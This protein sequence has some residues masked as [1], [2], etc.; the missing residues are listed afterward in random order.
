MLKS[1]HPSPK[2]EYL[3]PYWSKR[4]YPGK[5]AVD[6]LTQ[7]IIQNKKGYVYNSERIANKIANRLQELGWVFELIIPVPNYHTESSNAKAPALVK[8]LSGILSIPYQNDVLVRSDKSDPYR[9]YH[10]PG[11]R[12]EAA[13][14]DYRIND[15]ILKNSDH[16]SVRMI[17]QR[18]VLLVD[19]ILTSGATIEVC[20]DLLYENGAKIVYTF[21]AARTER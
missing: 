11:E 18:N 1:N 16:R 5:Y 9:R 4:Q 10:G 14:K 8:K 19:D 3:G 17:N 13:E 20:R 6:Q 15:Y 12:R 21:C 2:T 7:D